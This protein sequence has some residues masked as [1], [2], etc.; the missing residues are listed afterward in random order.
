MNTHTMLNCKSCMCSTHL[1][2][3][4]FPI[5]LGLLTDSK[6]HILSEF[7]VS[8]QGVFDDEVQFITLDKYFDIYF[9]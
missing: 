9:L 3:T 1:K 6:F 7:I 4:I 8:T 2:K 5:P